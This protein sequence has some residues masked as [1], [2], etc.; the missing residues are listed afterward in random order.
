MLVS[1]VS[2]EVVDPL[3]IISICECSSA[4]GLRGGEHEHAALPALL[5]KSLP[6]TGASARIACARLFM[7]LSFRDD[8]L[9]QNRHGLPLSRQRRLHISLH[10]VMRCVSCCL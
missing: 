6:C 4:S 9:L 8:C 5:R 7:R 2:S 3:D 1:P 10:G